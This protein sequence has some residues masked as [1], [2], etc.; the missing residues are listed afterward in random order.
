MLPRM[1]HARQGMYNQ[2]ACHCAF[3]ACAGTCETEHDPVPAMQYSKGRPLNAICGRGDLDPKNPRAY[4]CY[5]TKVADHSMALQLRAEGVVGPTGREAGLPPFRC[6]NRAS[7]CSV[8]TLALGTCL[9][10]PGGDAHEVHTLPHHAHQHCMHVAGADCMLALC[11][12]D[13]E[14]FRN[15]SHQGQPDVFDFVFEPLSAKAL[16]QHAAQAPSVAL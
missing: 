6:P 16:M 1:Q 12:W 5:D 11:R 8:P 7:S 9:E 4:G 13:G 10:L 14:A 3:T 2:S 15:V